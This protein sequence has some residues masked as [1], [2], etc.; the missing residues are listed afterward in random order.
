[1]ALKKMKLK[2]R[3]HSL[4]SLRREI[5][6]KKLNVKRRGLKCKRAWA[7]VII[8]FVQYSAKINNKLDFM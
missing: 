1:M 3:C 7:D 5:S 8:K 6:L 2:R 4:N